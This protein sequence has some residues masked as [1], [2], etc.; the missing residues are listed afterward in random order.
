MK[1]ARRSLFLALV[2]VCLFLLLASAASPRRTVPSRRPASNQE[3]ILKFQSLV[4]VHPDASLTVTETIKVKSRGWRIKR[5]IVRNFPTIY[6]D[7]AGRTVQ[8]GFEVLE[9]LKALP[10]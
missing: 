6:R 9:V 8:V 1:I 4:Q 7:K 5:G 2:A 3:Q 10:A